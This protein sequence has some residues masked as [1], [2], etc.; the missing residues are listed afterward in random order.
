M[1]ESLENRIKRARAYVAKMPEAFSGNRGHDTAFKVAEVLVRGFHLSIQDAWPIW[2]E[3]NQRCSPPWSY[4]EGQH[5]LESALKDGRMSFDC[6]LKDE[7]K[8]VKR[9]VVMRYHYTTAEGVEMF[10][11]L[12]YE[13]KF[14]SVQ[15]ADDAYKSNMTVKS[16]L[17]KLPDV[18]KAINSGEKIL[19]CEGEKDAL[20][21]FGF[22]FRAT[23]SAWGAGNWNE[24]NTMQL[25][26]ANVV[27]VPDTD[28][29]GQL[30]GLKRAK[31]LLG[32]AKSVCWLAIPEQFKD[33]T[34][35]AEAGVTK[36][37]LAGQISALEPI[38]EAFV[39]E[40]EKQLRGKYNKTESELFGGDDTAE[41]AG[42]P[43]PEAI[44]Y[45]GFEPETTEDPLE[46]L[47][48]SNEGKG[49]ILCKRH[50]ALLSGETGV[51]KSTLITQ[52]AIMF[53]LG[54]PL[55]GLTPKRPLKIFVFQAEN[56]ERDMWEKLDGT[57]ENVVKPLELEGYEATLKK[58]LLF[59][60]ESCGLKGEAFIRH[61]KKCCDFY[62]P[63]LIIADPL[64]AY[65]GSDVSDQGKVSDWIRNL[66]ELCKKECFAMFIIHHF[67]KP[68][69]EK[70]DSTV[71][72]A[73]GSSELMNTARV[74]FNIER[75]VGR[76]YR[77]SVFKRDDRLG[78]KD[79][80]NNQT[81][82]IL[83]KRAVPPFEYW[84]GL[85]EDDFAELK[86][87]G[88]RSAVNMGRPKKVGTD[89]FLKVLCDLCK[90]NPQGVSYS[91]WKKGCMQKLKIKERLFNYRRIELLTAQDVAMDENGFY[92]P[93]R[94]V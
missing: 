89:S 74:V 28:E 33:L 65:I 61:V 34:E 9:R 78:W 31:S 90:D 35:W 66:F 17:Y 21:A 92:Y 12:R 7:E 18:E 10:D 67:N 52:M 27:L 36:E 71:Y 85:D 76:F 38:N 4:Q 79:A 54:Q 64:Y 55:F 56:D 47:R 50:I 49:R 32:V 82:E 22:G 14:F 80:S 2:S 87:D 51:G 60:K 13:P 8:T 46:L 81:N 11:K 94:K 3:Y 77:F 44:T 43:F 86:E 62:H 75:K 45:D 68:R 73:S 23:T 83:I 19:L 39:Q 53:A 69:G 15:Y 24:I 88:K 1:M 37:Q 84:S 93:L 48:G 91:D 42:D 72:S 26:G 58:N 59:E 41:T 6:L 70:K 29:A 5:K 63:D 16:L 30:G 57:I 25:Q 20:T 40:R